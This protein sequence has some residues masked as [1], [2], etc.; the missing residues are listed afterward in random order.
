VIAVVDMRGEAA[1]LPSV[2]PGNFETAVWKR[3]D[4]ER[5]S[6]PPNFARASLSELMWSYVCRS[7]RNLLPERYRSCTIYFRRPPRVNPLLLSE[8]HLLVTRE[9]ALRPCRYEELVQKVE[10]DEGAVSRALAALYYVGAVTS[11]RARAAPTSLAAELPSQDSSSNYGA[12]AERH[13][14]VA[15]LRYLTVPAPVA[16]A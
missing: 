4:R 1:V 8:E 10:A 14:E 5:I 15:Y 7:S 6:V 12:L 16:L 3:V 13:I 2:R 11:T 9:L